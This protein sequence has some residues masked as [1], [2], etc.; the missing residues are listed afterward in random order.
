MASIQRWGRSTSCAA[1][2]QAPRRGD[3]GTSALP[4]RTRYAGVIKKQATGA[5]GMEDG[6]ALDASIP[7]LCLAVEVARR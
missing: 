3:R 2:R 7:Y 1:G 5:E 4:F 6:K